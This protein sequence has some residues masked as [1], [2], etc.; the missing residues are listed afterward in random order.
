M[1]ALCHGGGDCEVAVNKP[2]SLHVTPDGLAP[3]SVLFCS[4]RMPL[5]G[6]SA[7]QLA[8]LISSDLSVF[9]LEIYML[10]GSGRMENHKSGLSLAC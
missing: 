3:N 4:T 10:E 1:E 9:A 6:P 5:D 8:K 2:P 7:H